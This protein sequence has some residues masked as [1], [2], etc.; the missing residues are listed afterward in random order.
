MTATDGKW[1]D[2]DGARIEFRVNGPQSV[3]R[4][5]L[6]VADGRCHVEAD[7]SA[8]AHL[9]LTWKRG[10]EYVQWLLGKLRAADA[11]VTGMI[12]IDGDVSLL[13]PLLRLPEPA[14]MLD[15]LPEGL[16]PDLLGG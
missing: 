15:T 13:T 6:V 9:R 7:P 2:L 1:P 5:Q 16:R 3:H 12:A 11:A 8:P 10:A 14:A 4:S